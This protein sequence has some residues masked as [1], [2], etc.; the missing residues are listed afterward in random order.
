MPVIETAEDLDKAIEVYIAEANVDA[1]Q[2]KPVPD[3]RTEHREYVLGFREVT[4]DLVKL[5]AVANGDTNPLWRDK[6][7]AEKS[8]WGG[9][10]APPLYIYTAASIV[11]APV[12]ARLPSPQSIE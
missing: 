12:S 10:V 5:F 11:A 7:Y 1:G 3:R 4:E 6:A 8:P 9:I 2:V